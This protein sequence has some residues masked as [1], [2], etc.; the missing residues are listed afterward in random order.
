[1]GLTSVVVDIGLWWLMLWWFLFFF[2]VGADG[3]RWLWAVAVDLW[4]W[5]M[6]DFV[7]V[8]TYICKSFF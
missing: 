1:M 8:Y 7:C 5:V 3:G 6:E 4:V 2:F